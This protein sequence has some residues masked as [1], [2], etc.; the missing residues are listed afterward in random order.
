VIEK[1]SGG[2][3]SSRHRPFSFLCGHTFLSPKVEWGTVAAT[4]GPWR[5]E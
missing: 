5:Q 2:K 1:G 4:N 3:K